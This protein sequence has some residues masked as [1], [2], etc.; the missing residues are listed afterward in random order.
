VQRCAA[1]RSLDPRTGDQLIGRAR[2][3]VPMSMPLI[4]HAA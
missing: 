2:V 4:A 1:H 3:P